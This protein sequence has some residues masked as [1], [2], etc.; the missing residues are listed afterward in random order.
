MKKAYTVGIINNSTV[1]I[2]EHGIA[3]LIKIALTYKTGSIT[4]KFTAI[5][6]LYTVL[7][8]VGAEHIIHRFFP[9][10]DKDAAVVEVIVTKTA[11]AIGIIF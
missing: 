8:C 1:C 4:V 7:A 10:K 6:E 9:S 3:I 11:G 2:K 5:L